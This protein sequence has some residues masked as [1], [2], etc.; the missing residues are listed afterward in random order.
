M[1][2]HLSGH[3]VAKRLSRRSRPGPAPAVRGPTPAG[4]RG[5]SCGHWRQRVVAVMVANGPQHGSTSLNA[6]VMVVC[7]SARVQPRSQNG[8]CVVSITYARVSRLA[9]SGRH[10]WRF[11][12][13]RTYRTR[14]EM[15]PHAW[16]V[17]MIRIEC[18]R[19]VSKRTVR[20]KRHTDLLTSITPRH[21]RCEDGEEYY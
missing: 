8:P 15:R 19:S 2:V 1:L 3:Y 5:Q 7:V 10:H 20:D 18:V 4:R 14:I 12:T 21:S 9:P 17:C 13:T 11:T 6:G 16:N